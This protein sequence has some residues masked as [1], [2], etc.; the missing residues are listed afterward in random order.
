MYLLVRNRQSHLRK[1]FLRFFGSCI[2]HPRKWRSLNH[3][4][5]YSTPRSEPQQSIQWG[6]EVALVRWVLF[7]IVPLPQ[8]LWETSPSIQRFK[9]GWS[10]IHSTAIRYNYLHRQIRLVGWIEIARRAIWK[11]GLPF[12]D[13]TK[14]DQST[15]GKAFRG[16][17]PAHQI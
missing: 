8:K 11:A 12:T 5:E 1:R 17:K 9:L 6:I 7:C 10:G 16:V 15:F 14:S 3:C 13:W 4:S 2:P